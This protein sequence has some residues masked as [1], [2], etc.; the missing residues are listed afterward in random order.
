MGRLQSSKPTTSHYQISTVVEHQVKAIE[1]L[2]V[3]L[4]S[5]RICRKVNLAASTGQI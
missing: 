1:P 5:S 4:A 3:P 2:H